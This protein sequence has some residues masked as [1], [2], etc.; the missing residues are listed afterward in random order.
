MTT[1][2]ILSPNT[3]ISK[4][5]N[6]NFESMI[7]IHLM[8]SVLIFLFSLS[9]QQGKSQPSQ[10]QVKWKFHSN[11]K[12][13]GSPVIQSGLIYIGSSDSCLYALD[14]Q[15]GNLKWKFRS[16]GE[17]RSDALV[18]NEI[19]Y[20]Y[21]SSGNLYALNPRTGKLNWT[22]HTSGEKYYDAWD[23]Y[24]ASPVY[25][26]GTLFIG[27]GNGKLYA[28]NAFS[29]KQKWIF[30][31]PGPIH[32]TVTVDSNKVY[33]GSF[34]G[35]LYAL[36]AGSGKQV[37]KFKTIGDAYFPKGEIQKGAALDQGVLY[38]GSRDYNIYAINAKKGHGQ[39]NMKE[40]GS[41]VIAIPMV[42]EGNIYF[43][44][45]DS[46]SFYCMGKD[47]GDVK[48]KIPL[49]MRVFGSAVAKD[50]LVYFGCFNGKIYGA[51]Y[52]TGAIEWIFQ[53][54]GSKANYFSV[55]DE[56]DHF[57]KGFS[58]YGSDTRQ[59]EQTLLTLGSIHCTPAI[60]NKVIFFGST[61]G[62]FYAV[63]L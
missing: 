46:H 25:S 49:N 52:R 63:T 40:A 32:G 15:S 31:T 24:L 23:Y 8:K 17:I 9:F 50:S 56:N 51:N 37:W 18:V 34:D 43:G 13:V 10:G 21:N 35:T 11:G 16:N 2:S 29:G 55:Y 61:D 22:F 38:F 14:Q 6:E 1:L 41:W 12:I 42:Y 48:W 57:K 45:S 33:A 4:F 59:A 53:T 20:C 54:D 36:N 5:T 44:T 27:N 39:W 30:E 58:L 47:Y 26:Q 28:L 19:L 7:K 62:N 60:D 3:L